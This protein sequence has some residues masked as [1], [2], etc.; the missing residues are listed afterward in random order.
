MHGP[1][2]FSFHFLSFSVSFPKLTIFTILRLYMPWKMWKIIA[3]TWEISSWRLVEKFH[4]PA[5]LMYYSPYNWLGEQEITKL[6][7]IICFESRKKDTETSTKRHE[8]NGMT[9]WT[10]WY[11]HQCACVNAIDFAP[12][13]TT[14]YR[15]KNNKSSTSGLIL[16]ISVLARASAQLLYMVYI[17]THQS[18]P[19]GQNI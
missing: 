1:S 19:H 7:K 6:K 11:F 13:V 10:I 17:S 15:I 5:F 18:A 9:K 16:E 14:T 12:M 2:F 4:V 8:W 3:L